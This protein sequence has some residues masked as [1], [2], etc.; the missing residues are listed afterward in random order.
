MKTKQIYWLALACLL[1]SFSINAQNYATAFA[2]SLFNTQVFETAALEYEKCIFFNN[3][4][5]V[6]DYAIKQ[7]AYCF[8][9][10][11]NYYEAYKNFNRLNIEKYNDSLKCYYNYEMGL[12]LY[13]ENY[14]LDAD[15]VLQRNFNLNVS[16]QEYKNSIVLHVLVLNELN[17]YNEAKNKL[18]LFANNYAT[19]SVKDSILFIANNYY[20]KNNYPKLK[21]LNKARKLSKFLPGSGLFYIGKPG[22]ALGNIGFLLGSA[23]Y[24]GLN[25]YFGNYLT[26]ATAGFHLMR[27]FYTGGVNQLNDLVPLINYK[28]SRAFNDKVKNKLLC[29]F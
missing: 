18:V 24:T 22:R 11:G 28:R 9:S 6:R 19:T 29:H 14:F 1:R 4:D 10:I 16:S 8:K 26:S 17:K 13:L 15:K 21:S 25:I 2:D 7:R 3:N 23:A 5:S 12:M 20:T 27:L